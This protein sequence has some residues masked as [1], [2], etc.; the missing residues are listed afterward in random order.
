M[1]GNIFCTMFVQS[2]TN[3]MRWKRPDSLTGWTHERTKLLAQFVPEGSRVLE[4]GAGEMALKTFLPA[5]CTY[6]P[7]DL[8]PRCSDTFVCDLNQPLPRE[9]PIHDVAVFSGVFEYIKDIRAVMR[10]LHIHSNLV[11]C[12]YSPATSKTLCDRLFRRSRGWINDFTESQFCSAFK[13]EGF[14]LEN[15]GE[16][17]DQ[18]LFCFRRQHFNN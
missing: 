15:Q 4:F 14:H 10:W 8:I 9:C 16:W 2:G 5:S 3:L 13:S 7:S 18:S 11:V 6:I 1:V 12:S 17:S